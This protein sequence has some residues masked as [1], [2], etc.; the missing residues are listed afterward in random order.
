MDSYVLG[1]DLGSASIGW[2]IVEPNKRVVDCGVR[3]FDPGVNLEAFTK[4]QE[5]SSNNVARR[6]ARLHRRQ[7]RRRAGRQRELFRLLQQHQL[8]PGGQGSNASQD[9]HQTLQH[10]D[11]D[12]RK[13]WQQRLEN[14]GVPEQ[15]LIYLLRKCALDERLESDELGRIFYHLGQRRGFK[16]TRRDTRKVAGDGKRGQEKGSAAKDEIGKVK[17]SIHQLSH[18]M[19]QAGARTLGEYFAHIAGSNERI[20]GRWTDRK[21]YLAEFEA[22]WASQSKYH[23][24]L[25]DEL[26]RKVHDLLF[27]QRPIAKNDHLIG[28]CD[29]EPKERRAPMATLLAQRFRLVQKVNDLEYGDGIYMQALTAEQRSQLSEALEDSGG[30]KFDQI[31]AL[32]SL[33]KNMKFNL[34]RGGEKRIPGNRTNAAMLRAIP[35]RWPT[36][37]LEDRNKT[38]AAWLDADEDEQ[39]VSRLMVECGLAEDDARALCD[40]QPEDSYHQLSLKAM[41]RLLPLLESGARFKTAEERVYGTSFS[42]GKVFDFLAPVNEVLPQIPNPAVVRALTEL[43]KV[44]NAIVRKYAKPGEIRI[45]LARELKRNARQRE[46]DWRSMRRRE[47]ARK[48]ALKRILEEAHRPTPSGQDIERVLLFE[49]CGGICAYCGQAFNFQQLFDGNIEVE[50]ILP[51]NKFND[52]SFSNK[53]LAHRSCNQTKLGRTP[54]EAFSANEEEWE[55]I[56]GRVARWNNPE[57]LQRF[58]IKDA[59]ELDPDNENGFA[60]RRLNDTR[61]VSKLAARYLS[62]LYGGRDLRQPDGKAKRVIFASAGLL[63]A[64]LR[65]EW[66]LEKILREPE[67]ASSSRK[68]GKPRTDHRHHAIDAIVI[69]LTSNAHIVRYSTA[70]ASSGNGDARSLF[71]RVASPWPN[72]VDTVRPLIDRLVVSH[73]PSHKLNG[74]LHDETNYSA[75]RE[76]A[77]SSNGRKKSATKRVVHVRKPVHLLSAKQI[78]EDI[79]DLAVRRAV[80]AKLERVGDPKK[81]ETDHPMLTTRSGKQVPILRAR[82]RASTPVA[83]IASGERERYVA[84]AGNHHVAIFETADKKGQRVWESP[85]VVSRLDA[86]QRRSRGESVIE[87]ALNGAEDARYLFSLMSGDAVEMDDA[88]LG[89]RNIFIVRTVSDF[90]ITFLR[91]ADARK[92]SDLERGANTEA[93]L[94]RALSIDKLRQWSCR[95]VF[96]DVLGKARG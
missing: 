50:H 11:S 26:K 18:A 69:A 12:L 19:E 4:G 63:T 47:S 52:N 83:R 30:L 87:K 39:L 59:V 89:G 54:F 96:V 17:A 7:L 36:L 95:K 38:V 53:T 10:L 22:I 93:D 43:R 28:M 23:P 27:F 94:V 58:K 15:L 48:A 60:A 2:A 82:V 64:T 78:A 80:V 62:T 8:L 14:E 33:G 35:E 31:R 29:L 25:T 66:Q 40:V 46:L 92:L 75:P 67:A 71:G 70:A 42:G 76:I 41:E 90:E 79:V 5:G 74:P 73:R 1:L 84:S 9:R 37:S 72:F 32:L 57:K 49:E 16:S 51:I 21:M 88:K 34:E 91:H 44:V 81:F 56:L 86:V 24:A 68:P 55:Q 61:Y 45:E 13:R 3:I 6:M 20:R 77:I 85:G 65:R